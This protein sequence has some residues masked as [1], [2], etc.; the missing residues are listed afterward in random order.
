MHG[1]TRL[2]EFLTLLRAQA[3]RALSYFWGLSALP[4]RM[5]LRIVPGKIQG[6]WQV[7]VSSPLTL[8]APLPW[9]SSPRMA[10]RS[11]DWHEQTQKTR[12]SETILTLNPNVQ[13]NKHGRT[14]VNEVLL[15]PL[16]MTKVYAQFAISVNISTIWVWRKT[17]HW[18][19]IP[20]WTH[21]DNLG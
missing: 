16:F 4:K 8:T 11:E 1:A 20:I 10:L 2:E 13:I 21:C 5:L 12:M 18:F 9:L 14:G 7:Y 3:L 17:V 15:L 6:C 19:L